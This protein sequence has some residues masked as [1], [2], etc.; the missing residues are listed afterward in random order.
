[1][2]LVPIDAKALVNLLLDWADSRSIPITPMK[3][4]K[5]AYYCHA[6]FLVVTG[7]PLIAQEFEAWEYGPVISG[8]FHEF[9]SFGRDAIT[10]RASRFDP[11]LAK[12][13][14]V[15]NA[16]LGSF[17]NI[18]KQAFDHYVSY[19][20]TALSNMSHVS[21]GPWSEALRQ[22]DAGRNPG[23]KIS[24]RLILAHHGPSPLDSVH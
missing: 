22:F 24:N 2:S 18:V 13:E 4:Q 9:K 17:H 8:V 7:H 14:L 15:Q 3:L 11:I 16:A 5:L 21:S 19:S 10:S 1:M 23:R 12:R 6:E 20:A